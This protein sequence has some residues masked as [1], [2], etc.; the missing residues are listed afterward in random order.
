M[1]STTAGPELTVLPAA[2]RHRIAPVAASSANISSPV[3]ATDDA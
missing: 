1:P 2:N 3:L